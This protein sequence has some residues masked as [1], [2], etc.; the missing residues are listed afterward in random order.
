MTKET[1]KMYLSPKEAARILGVHEETILRWCKAANPL[2]A[3][4]IGG[5][6]KIPAHKVKFAEA[7]E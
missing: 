1:K 2:K 5:R 7:V 3:K 4:K 6:W